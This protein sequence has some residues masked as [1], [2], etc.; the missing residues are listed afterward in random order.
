[1]IAPQTGPFMKIPEKALKIGMGPE[2][3]KTEARA[4]KT[5]G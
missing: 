2:V 4:K 3:I 1:M 5:H